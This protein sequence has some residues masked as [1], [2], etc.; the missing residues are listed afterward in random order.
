MKEI[1]QKLQFFDGFFGYYDVDFGVKTI[2][3]HINCVLI[4][5]LYMFFV[6]EM[7]KLFCAFSN[8]DLGYF[9]AKKGY[10][11]QKLIV[12]FLELVTRLELATCWLRI[13]CT[14][15]CATPAKNERVWHNEVVRLHRRWKDYTTVLHQRLEYY[16][17]NFSFL[18]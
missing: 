7:H 9:S 16:T 12:S 10:N 8:S 14:T 5:L 13:S 2:K 11:E 3:K 15:D 4:C 18:Q 1:I 17:I 6:G